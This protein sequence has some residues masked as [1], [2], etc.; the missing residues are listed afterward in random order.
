MWPVRT[1][2]GYPVIGPSGVLCGRQRSD[3]R[4]T[5]AGF[6][7]IGT[8]GLRYIVS[9]QRKVHCKLEEINCEVM[10]SVQRQCRPHVQRGNDFDH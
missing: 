3:L 10:P 6:V 5:S 4:R 9:R 7:E 8:N 2:R 1:V